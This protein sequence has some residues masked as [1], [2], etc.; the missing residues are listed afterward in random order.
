M[1]TN[2]EIALLVKF[3]DLSEKHKAKFIVTIMRK[4]NM[5]VSLKLISGTIVEMAQHGT[6]SVILC[7]NVLNNNV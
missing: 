2:Y 1:R 4:K 3:I 7:S 6:F 5:F